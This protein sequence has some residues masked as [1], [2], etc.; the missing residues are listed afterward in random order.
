[1]VIFAET[2]MWCR[3]CRR[4][5]E[6]VV[7]QVIVLVVVLGSAL[8]QFIGETPEVKAARKAFFEEYRRRAKL[9][10]EA[11]DIHIF[12]EDPKDTGRPSTSS[13]FTFSTNLGANKV[14]PVA[15]PAPAAREIPQPAAE[16]P[17]R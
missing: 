11:P 8:A 6:T 7:L 12:F 1:M 10:E 13:T 16:A 4:G 5:V 2:F 17:L 14:I 15:P 3:C 9:A